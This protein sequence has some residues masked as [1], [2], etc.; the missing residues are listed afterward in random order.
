MSQDD[1]LK[2]V[3]NLKNNKARGEDKIVNEY[4]KAT[5]NRFIGIY[6]KLFNLI[7]DTGIMP[8][9]WLSGIIKLFIRT[10]GIAMIRKITDQ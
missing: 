2:C 9:S 4:I 7:F 8:R 3:E 10:K 5:I 6:E 1:I